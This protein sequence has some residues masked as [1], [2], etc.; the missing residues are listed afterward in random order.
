MKEDL[1]SQTD[2]ISPFLTPHFSIECQTDDVVVRTKEEI[3]EENKMRI[4]EKED[5]EKKWK[6]EEERRKKE[7]TVKTERPSTP[8]ETKPNGEIF[9]FTNQ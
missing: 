6:E 2:F 5:D 9:Y 3:E 4:K 7:T 8:V 1:A